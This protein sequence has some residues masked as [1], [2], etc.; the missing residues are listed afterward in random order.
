MNSHPS[1]LC[2]KS[3]PTK[4]G[5]NEHLGEVNK[6]EL[7]S[8]KQNK[9]YT[10]EHMEEALQEIMVGQPVYRCS[11]KYNIP[12]R[13]LIDRL[14]SLGI[15]LAPTPHSS[16]EQPKHG[17]NFTCGICDSSFDGEEALFEHLRKDN[18]DDIDAMDDNDSDSL[19]SPE[20]IDLTEATDE[21]VLPSP[22]PEIQRLVI[23]RL[24]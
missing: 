17:M 1:G 13:S 22:E 14:K 16:S 21:Y 5:L 20:T 3:L 18:H 8:M 24:V 9:Q 7:A 6:I 12:V 4:D 11:S 15:N 19:V 10:E 2:S 23:I